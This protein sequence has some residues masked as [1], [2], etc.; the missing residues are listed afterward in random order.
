MENVDLLKNIISIIIALFGWYIVHK[1]TSLRELKNKQREIRI[2]YLL[3]TYKKL[4]RAIDYHNNE[5]FEIKKSLE[6]AISEIQ[7][8]GT[9]KQII[10]SQEIGKSFKE[11]GSANLKELL[12]QLRND[13]R[14]E[15]D[16][17]PISEDIYNLRI[18][19]KG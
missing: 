16:L 11:K 13:L 17:E 15:L 6:D 8:V 4:E 10:L 2:N 12:I 1:F 18:S 5:K 14:K 7:L 19:I 9:R 3:N